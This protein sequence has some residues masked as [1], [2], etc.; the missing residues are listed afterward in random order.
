[1]SRKFGVS[2]PTI[3]HIGTGRLWPHVSPDGSKLE[4]PKFHSWEKPSQSP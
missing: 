1:L 3:H 2:Q 4:G